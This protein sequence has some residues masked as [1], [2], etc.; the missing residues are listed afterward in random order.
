MPDSPAEALNDRIPMGLWLAP[1][2]EVFYA[3]RG[4]EELDL[5]D[6]R[7]FRGRG[8]TLR[9]VPLRDESPVVSTST[10][11]GIYIYTTEGEFRPYF[12]VNKDDVVGVWHQSQ[13][14][15]LDMTYI[16]GPPSGVVVE[17]DLVA[18]VNTNALEQLRQ[19]VPSASREF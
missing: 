19:S 13:G 5:E 1:N 10:P 14:R 6:V 9:R 17:T 2:G 8:E 18:T 7:V 3:S 11:G 12:F 15:R 4:P 16:E